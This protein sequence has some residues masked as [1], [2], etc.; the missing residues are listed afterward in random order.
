V[1]NKVRR[2]MNAPNQPAARSAA[3]RF[4][5]GRDEL[6]TGFH[7]K[8]KD[9]RSNTGRG[10]VSIP[11]RPIAP[12]RSSR[13]ARAPGASASSRPFQ[14]TP[15][16]LTR[17]LYRVRFFIRR[18]D[19]CKR[20]PPSGCETVAAGPQFRQSLRFESFFGF[21]LPSTQLFLRLGG[22]KRLG[23]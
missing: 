6:R 9:Q 13:R 22:G 10:Y 18:S 3:Q 11:T 19:C 14:H 5:D 2:P 7:Y 15:P 17:G 16:G 23:R 20:L 21:R 1:L 12:R 8:S 4:A